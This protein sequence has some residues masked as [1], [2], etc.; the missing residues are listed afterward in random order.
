MFK[1]YLLSIALIGLG[2]SPAC[3][4]FER[5]I[6]ITI[7][8]LPFVGSPHLRTSKTEPSQ[9][10]F[11][12]L[13]QALIDNNVPATGFV[14]AGSIGKGQWQL[15]EQFQ[16]AGFI[17]GNHTYTHENLNTTAA[18]KYIA[19][20]AKAD[21]ILAPLMSSTRYFRYPYL[22]EG[23]GNKKQQVQKYLKENNYVIAPVTI[24][25]KDFL[26]NKKLYQKPASHREEHINQIKQKYLSYIWRETLLAENEI[27]QSANPNAKQILLIHANLLNSYCMGDIIELFKRNGYRFISLDEALQQPTRNPSPKV[28]TTDMPNDMLDWEWL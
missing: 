6:A 28:V 16:Q 25:S 12:S 2:L 20:V 5:E 17:L 8:D 18:D 27:K 1:K 13:M 24:D 19:N 3:F 21:Q 10:R 15:L 4:A 11:L 26:F 22:A 23:R 9:N 14:I 7:D